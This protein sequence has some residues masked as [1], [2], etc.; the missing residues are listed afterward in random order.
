MESLVYF[1]LKSLSLMNKAKAEATRLGGLLENKYGDSET[2][3]Y[4]FG[5][6]SGEA[7]EKSTGNAT[8]A[9]N[10]PVV[11]EKFDDFSQSLSVTKEQLCFVLKLRSDDPSTA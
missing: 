7:E 11:S 4:Y 5:F 3:T 2:D 8:I 1:K 10:D 6:K 9:F